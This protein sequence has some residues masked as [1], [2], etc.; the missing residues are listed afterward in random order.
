MAC[1]YC[2]AKSPRT[3]RWLA[4]LASW[5]GLSSHGHPKA[6]AADHD[7]PPINYSSAAPDNPISLLEAKINQGQVNLDYDDEH[8]YLPALLKALQVPLSSQV[9][10]FSRT[11]LQ[12]SRIG[13]RT[14]RAIYFNDDV[15]IGYCRQGDVMEIAASDA[16]LGTVFYTLD[17]KP[18]PRIRFARHT[19]MCL[20]CHGSS[21]NQG[22]PG[23]LARSVSPD[24]TGEAVLA[25]GSRRV[26]HTTPLEERWGGW[27]VTGTSGPKGHMG[28]Q[29]VGG[30]AWADRRQTLD[31]SNLTDLSPFFTVANYL[32]PHSDIVALMVLEHQ[33]EAL[34][35]LT[36]ANFLTRL[37]LH[38]QAELNR[39][40]QLP[41]DHPRDSITQR[42]HWACESV[43]KYFLFCD[44]A[45]LES[46][47]TGTSSFA[48]EFAA[49]GPFDTKGRSLRDFD[50]KTRLFRYPLSYLVYSRQFDALPL[51]A[52]ERIYLRLWE[53]LTGKDQSPAF[54]HLSL[55]D[56]Q[57]IMEILRA[58]KLDL[59]SSW[60]Q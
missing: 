20:L 31:Y 2:L 26:D 34:N 12:R 33:N 55:D 3:I 47:I 7:R 45:R 32:S 5:L 22:F 19:E 49:R 59:P 28:N 46:P 4:I 60:K 48:K 25:R 15:T 50:L 29:I 52:K 35:H 24:S 44:E 16:N 54:Q 18:Q 30:W 56:R 11:S 27:Y 43:V 21:A 8:G 42:I 1:R 40:F 36:R 17:Q 53:V 41:A 23:H 6:S 57:A 10:V 39:A 51:P 37:A 58:T 13:P 9:L 14:P 38:E